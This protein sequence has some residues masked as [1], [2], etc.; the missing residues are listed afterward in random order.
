MALAVL[1]AIG[2]LF[3][4]DPGGAIA[5]SGFPEFQEMDWK[6][7]AVWGFR[8]IGMV[9]AQLIIIVLWFWPKWRPPKPST[10]S[11]VNTL[12]GSMPAA[13]VFAL[14]GH[15]IWTLTLLASILEMCQRGT[16]RI[17]AVETRVG[18]LYRLSRQGPTQYDWERTICDSLPARPTSIDALDEALKKRL[19]AI[20]D[21]IGDYLQRQGLFHDNPVRVRRENDDDSHGWGLPVGP[22]MGVG[23]GFWAALWLDLWWANALIGALIGL[24]YMGIT[25][26]VL[27]GMLKPTPAGA[28]EISQWFGWRD[29]VAGSGSMGARDHSDPM[30]PYAVALNVAQ[31]WLDVAT[32]APS[33]FGFGSASSLRG[34]DLD[35]AYHAFLH[36]PEWYLSGRSNDA[37]KAAAQH[38]YEEELRLLGQLDRLELPDAETTA[39]LGREP[40]RRLKRL[41]VSRSRGPVPHQPQRERRRRRI[42]RKGPRGWLGKRRV[43][44]A[45][46]GASCGWS[47]WQP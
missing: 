28:L 8:T 45:S 16:L 24:V 32:P 14:Q 15:A 6:Q 29:A 4:M 27:T 26:T 19:D 36:A 34:A 25:P 10:W 2:L 11:S 3:V 23:V 9:V 20:G 44:G 18:F 37:S 35:A 7:L 22:L 12:P 33:W 38:G 21:Q 47:A 31:P 43:A 46:A 1:A 30:L 41:L 40:P 39:H 42:S 17:E 13:A 5:E